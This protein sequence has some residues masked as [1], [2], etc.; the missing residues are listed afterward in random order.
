L[1][2]GI[3]RVDEDILSD[4]D[5]RRFLEDTK[6]NIWISRR[7]GPVV[8][9]VRKELG[10]VDGQVS[11]SDVVPE[12]TAEAEVEEAEEDIEQ[13]VSEEEEVVEVEVVKKV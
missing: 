6:D 4:Q 8:A 5:K 2:E 9:Q 3:G 12:Q 11:A 13:E 7:H 10:L 1:A